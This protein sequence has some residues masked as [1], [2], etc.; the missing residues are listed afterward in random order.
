VEETHDEERGRGGGN[1]G[2][3]DGE[4]APRLR[5]KIGPEVH[6]VVPEKDGRG[7]EAQSQQPREDAERKPSG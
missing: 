7:G 6:E 5:R 3:G 2:R 4:K 1:Y